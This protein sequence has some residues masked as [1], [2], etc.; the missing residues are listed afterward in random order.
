[1]L[2]VREPIRFHTE[3]VL[4]D[5][6]KKDSMKIWKVFSDEAYGGCSTA[7]FTHNDQGFATFSGICS[8]AIQ[9]SSTMKRSGFCGIRSHDDEFL[10]MSEFDRLVFKV[11]GTPQSYLASIRTYNFLTGAESQD[12]WQAFFTCK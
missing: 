10:D 3:D 6:S 11:R 5:F 9:D 8:T 7:A 12:V 2:T 4:F 1:M